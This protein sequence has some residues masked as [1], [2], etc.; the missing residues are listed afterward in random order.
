LSPSSTY[1]THAHKHL[2]PPRQ[3]SALQPDV[4]SIKIGQAE[5]CAHARVCLESGIQH[6]QL[7][8]RLYRRANLEHTRHARSDSGLNLQVKV[9]KYLK[10][11][12]FRS[13][14]DAHRISSRSEYSTHKTATAKFW[15]WPS[16]TSPSTLSSFSQATHRISLVSK[17]ASRT[18]TPHSVSIATIPVAGTSLNF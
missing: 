8:L 3:T 6:P 10:V 4:N 1:H 12:P 7:P 14:A 5:R 17:L 15:T 18:R 13:D 11:F 2:S 9:L 16:G